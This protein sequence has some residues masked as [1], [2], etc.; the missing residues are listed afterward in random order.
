L[1]KRKALNSWFGRDAYEQT[2][3]RIALRAVF[4]R[5]GRRLRAIAFQE[6]TW[7]S[8][9]DVVNQLGHN[10]DEDRAVLLLT[11]WA[12]SA[13]LFLVWTER[14]NFLYRV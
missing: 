9:M 14:K 8:A 12:Q 6:E 11:L 2:G 10:V 4:F 5:E 7:F 1:K 13:V 3:G